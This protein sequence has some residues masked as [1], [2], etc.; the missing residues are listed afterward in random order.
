MQIR[1]GK[2]D[3]FYEIILNVYWIK[4]G[5][6]WQSIMK[7]IIKKKHIEKYIEEKTK[8][9]KLVFIRIQLNRLIIEIMLNIKIINNENIM[10]EDKLVMQSKLKLWSLTKQYEV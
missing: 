7:H 4:I 6:V 5:E 3:N 9:G 10:I 2:Q 8:K 1:R